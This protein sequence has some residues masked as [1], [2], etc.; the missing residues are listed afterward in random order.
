MG[1]R[2]EQKQYVVESLASDG[3]ESKIMGRLLTIA[4]AAA[5]IGGTLG[6]VSG[7]TLL[8]TTGPWP[9]QP[10]W[11]IGVCAALAAAAAVPIAL[12]AMRGK[13]SVDA[14]FRVRLAAVLLGAAAGAGN[15]RSLFGDHPA[16]RQL[17]CVAIGALLAT[18]LT[19][20]AA[21]M[22][23]Q[24][25]A[26]PSD[27]PR[28]RW[29]QF[30]LGSLLALM[31]LTSA[32][33]SLWVRGPMARRRVLAAIEASGGGRVRYASR[34]PEWIVQLLG[35][36]ARAFFDEVDAIDL[37]DP[38]D[39]DLARLAAFTR[40]RSLQV[41][42]NRISDVGLEAM[43]Q[44]SSLEELWL[45]LDV[46]SSPVLARPPA[47][48]AIADANVTA[49]GIAQLRRLP[50]LRSLS[51]PDSIADAGLREISA[52]N[53]LEK[54]WIVSQGNLP[55]VWPPLTAAGTAHLAKL[56]ML[57]ELHLSHMPL[58]D[59]EIAFIQSLT[60]LR[61]LDLDQ[62]D[63]TD[64][65][66]IHLL[67]LHELESLSLAGNKITGDGFAGLS[68]PRLRQLHLGSA[69]ITD[70]GLSHLAS[71]KNLTHLYLTFGKVT[72]S[73]MP[74]LASLAELQSL[75]LS[76][77]AITDAGLKQLRSL[78]KLTYLGVSA[79]AITDEGLKHLEGL[80]EMRRF[81]CPNT[82]AT[83]AGIQRLEDAWRRQRDSANR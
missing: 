81:D 61:R 7:V 78:A 58:G 29:S 59:S 25:T 83:P 63:V 57:R 44:L 28:G 46:R 68:F 49:A 72:D 19:R 26:R 71:F 2:F 9:E 53:H 1:R 38:A 80:K 36:S 24:T 73:G 41:S 60:R 6:A 39:A 35:S 33:L 16:G 13:L 40:L 12:I 42:G 37:H 11:F 54:L 66:L 67:P 69:G 32:A 79:T 17:L 23:G 48:L 82:S 75:E 50:R 15:A 27:G 20:L 5:V 51:L 8:A 30:T 77:T 43:V 52:L 55:V 62:T 65:G 21:Q 22:R 64:A 74:Y 18:C 14:G 31:V 10:R 56:T 70:R 45:S 47:A 3:H 4:L 34:A 76:H